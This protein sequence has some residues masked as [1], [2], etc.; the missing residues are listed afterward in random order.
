ME[1]FLLCLPDYFSVEYSINPWMAGEQVNVQNAKIQWEELVRQ[2][3]LAGGSVKTISPVNGLQDMV[4][5]CNAG[6]A[7]NNNFVISA[8]RFKERR[9]ESKH[10]RQWLSKNGYNIIDIIPGLYFE[11]GG[12]ALVHGNSL[13]GGYGYRTDEKSLE[14]VGATLGLD[15]H[16]LRLKD[17]RFYH[18]DTCFCRISKTHAIYYPDAFAKGE[19]DKLKNV[20]ELIPISEHDARLFMCNSMLVGQTLLI[21]SRNSSIEK[22]INNTLGIKTVYVEVGEFLKSGGAIQCLCL[23][24]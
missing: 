11:G 23:K 6:I 1:A 19:I 20:I 3:K 24:L 17:P 2:I 7:H 22:Y 13:I 9:G 14:I 12:D 8:M 4:F 5:A 10:Y 15:T 18:L 21:P 16:T